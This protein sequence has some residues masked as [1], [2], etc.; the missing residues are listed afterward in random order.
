MLELNEVDIDT[1][2]EYPDNPRQGDIYKISESLNQ[3]GQYRPLT[4]NKRD[5]TILTGNHTWKAMKQLGWKTCIVTYVDV[6]EAQAKKIVLVDNRL[7]DIAGYDDELLSKMLQ[8]IV[9]SGDF[10]GTG[11]NAKEIDEL[12]EEMNTEVDDYDT[13]FEEVKG[14]K[15]SK[16]EAVH[17]I[18]LYLD[19][20]QFEKYKKWVQ[21]LAEEMKCNLTEA[22]YNAVKY[23][24][25]DL[26]L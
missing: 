21:A 15:K 4:V 8:E 12:L 1:L 18:V 25:D 11:F 23:T 16:Q 14:E 2:N 20:K 5:M 26:G 19:D 10:L 13:E 22:T 3:H 7:G 6:D 17:D 24:Y 9:D